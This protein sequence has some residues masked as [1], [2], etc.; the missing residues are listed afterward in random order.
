MNKPIQTIISRRN[1]TIYHGTLVSWCTENEF[2][3]IPQG[4]HTIWWCKKDYWEFKEGIT[5]FKRA[6]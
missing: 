6:F 4:E 2:W 5:I 3:F 1:G